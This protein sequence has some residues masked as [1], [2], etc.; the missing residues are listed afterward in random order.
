[1]GGRVQQVAPP[2]E[3]YGKPVNQ[4]VAGFIGMPPMNFFQGVVSKM[5]SG[6]CF[7]RT[8]IEDDSTKCKR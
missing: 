7:Q 2:M 6:H 5:N 1:M 8:G 3:V 4:F